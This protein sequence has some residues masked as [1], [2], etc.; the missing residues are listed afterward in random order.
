M[1]PAL[2]LVAIAGAALGLEV[3]E[4]AY[5]A[6]VYAE[7][8]AGFSPRG[9]K[10]S[11]SISVVDACPCD[12]ITNMADFGPVSFVG[13]ILAVPGDACT[14]CTAV[15]AACAAKQAC[16]RQ[17]AYACSE[18]GLLLPEGFGEGV[19]DSS[20]KCEDTDADDDSP[21]PT[22]FISV[23]ASTALVNATI[24]S[25]ATVNATMSDPDGDVYDCTPLENV[26]FIYLGF[27]P[28]W[29]VA[30]VLWVVTRVHTWLAG[31][32]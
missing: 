14:E 23:N 20:D 32:G 24:W 31:C 10:R 15:Q 26:P 19:G 17:E 30:F 8:R 9:Y 13:L 11:G 4:P 29:F 25:T 5:A 28:V 1:R 2:F 21:L 6:G 12:W 3:H 22:A 7:T 27:V 16:E 18:A